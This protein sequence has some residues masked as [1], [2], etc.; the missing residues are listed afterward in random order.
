MPNQSQKEAAA[1]NISR[2]ARRSREMRQKRFLGREIVSGKR[3]NTCVFSMEL[4]SAQNV[5]DS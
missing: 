3:G 5:L 4:G 1:R 2:L